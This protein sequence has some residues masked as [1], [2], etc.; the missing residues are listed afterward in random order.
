[1]TWQVLLKCPKATGWRSNCLRRVRAVQLLTS[2]ALLTGSSLM[3]AAQTSQPPRTTSP[4]ATDTS[5]QASPTG[6]R[7][8]GAPATDTS[9]QASPLPEIRSPGFVFAPGTSVRISL[10]EALDSGHAR[11]G[12]SVSA[13][14]VAEIRAGGSASSSQRT[15]NGSKD[16]GQNESRDGGHDGSRTGNAERTLPAGTPVMLTVIESVP[17][18]R[19]GA[20]GELSLQVLR[21][22]S[23]AVFTDT[24]TFHGKPGH[25]DLPDSAPQLGTEASFAAGAQLSF[26]IQK[27]PS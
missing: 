19:L 11:N 24:Q 2:F 25:Q 15:Q 8:P 21:V 10:T 5:V 26:T 7:P 17:V 6:R 4:P 20:A 23:L 22:G 18:G 14:L 3:S 1:M 16:G 13:M 12:Q 9:A 27:P